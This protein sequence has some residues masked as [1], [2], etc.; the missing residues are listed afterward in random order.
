[1]DP[2]RQ[3]CAERRAGLPSHRVIVLIALVI[4]WLCLLAVWIAAIRS[5]IH[6][7]PAQLR[8]AGRSHG[9]TLALVILTGS[10]GAI[11]YWL[12]IKRQVDAWSDTVS[13]DDGI[14][15]STFL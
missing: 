12:V 2:A 7:S 1:M 14:D 6:Y 15:R 10:L 4:V 3:R 11:Y 13:P 5:T 9:G 8:A